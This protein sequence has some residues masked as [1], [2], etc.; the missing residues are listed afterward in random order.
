MTD[1]LLICSTMAMLLS[2]V[3]PSSCYHS[4]LPF[5]KKNIYLGGKTNIFGAS[6]SVYIYYYSEHAEVNSTCFGRHMVV[7][8]RSQRNSSPLPFIVSLLFLMPVIQVS[9]LAEFKSFI[10]KPTLTVVDFFATWC[11]PCKAIAPQLEH[12]SN[13]KPHVTFLKVNVDACPDVMREYPVRCMP[14]FMFFKSGKNI[15]SFEGAD[16]NSIMRLVSDNEVIPPPPIPSSEE[17]ANMKPKELLILMNRH[18]INSSGLLE[19][20]ELIAEIEKYR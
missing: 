14:T 9:A 13:N 1:E 12:L 7:T 17:L 15:E 19:K 8:H 11:G 6:H 18:G 10:A 20:P 4:I 5:G 2:S 3:H 16:I